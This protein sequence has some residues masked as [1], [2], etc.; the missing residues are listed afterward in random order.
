MNSAVPYHLGFTAVALRPE[1]ARIVAEA[2]LASGDWK[3]ARASVLSSNALQLKTPAGAQ[4]AERELRQRLQTLTQR[5][6]QILAESSADDRAA[7]AWLAVMKFSA[8]PFEFATEVLREKLASH[9]ETLR[10]SD[11]EGF[12]EERTAGHPELAELAEATRTKIRTMLRRI[13]L[14]AGLL[15]AGPL[16]GQ[17][18]RPVLSPDAV[19]AI[20]SDDP[21]WLAGFL[22]PDSEI[23]TV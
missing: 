23:N 21:R 5:Q 14:E 16:L 13:L 18:Q 15:T 3:V 11:Y 2:Y 17:V 10:P 22:V 12:I 4:R 20:S 19:Q 9:D 7:M 8:F 1:L 6:L